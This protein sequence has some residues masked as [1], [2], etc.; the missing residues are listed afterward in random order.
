MPQNNSLI[1]FREIS[2]FT[3][4][5]W[6]SANISHQFYGFAITDNTQ[7]TLTSTFSLILNSKRNKGKR[8]GTSAYLTAED[9]KISNRIR[10]SRQWLWT[11]K[12]S[13]WEKMELVPVCWYY[14]QSVHLVL[15]SK[16]E[17][18]L[19]HKLPTWKKEPCQ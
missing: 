1:N 11:H 3:L 5:N 10:A 16:Q 2:P 4:T 6:L 17:W 13:K 12:Y 14:P 9:K 7:T 18:S 8:K 19:L 15:S